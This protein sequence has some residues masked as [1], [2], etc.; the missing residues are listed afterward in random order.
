[1]TILPVLVAPH[2]VLTRKSAPVDHIGDGERRLLD[3]MLETMYAAPGIG[4]A[5]PQVGVSR[6][7]L[8][9]D[10]AGPDAAPEPRKFVNPEIIS[11]SETLRPHE[12][13]CLSFPDQF[14]EIT[15]PD[16]IAVRYLDE[17]GIARELEAEGLLCV[18]IQHEMDHLDGVNFVD[19]LS[20][21]KRGMILRKLRK[22]KKQGKF[23]A[24]AE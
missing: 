20:D 5:A 14:A 2:P 8:V 17:H 11:A 9:V 22:M 23:Q 15:R 10:C 7:M 6:R 3:D 21:L 24:A 18:C 16:R 12:E 1:M 19:Y 13:G 4:L